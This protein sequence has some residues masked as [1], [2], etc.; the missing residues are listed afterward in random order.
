[1][2]P[3]KTG[4]PKLS[5]AAA[6]LAVIATAVVLVALMQAESGRYFSKVVSLERGLK[7]ADRAGE[8]GYRVTLPKGYRND[9]RVVEQAIVLEDGVPLPLRIAKIQ[10]VNEKGRGRYRLTQRVVYISTPDNSDPRSN[11]RKYE[12]S[13]PREVRPVALWLPL[14]LL[15][16]ALFYLQRFGTPRLPAWHLRPWVEPALVLAV[17]FSAM[18]W[19]LNHFSTYSDG[20][21]LNELDRR[22]K[23]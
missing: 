5:V 22:R 11:G 8:F 16:G 12:L 14:A 6:V 18:I 20:C 2:I 23:Y 1:M 10:H 7:T 19:A 17:S 4:N 3:S 15:T 21:G 9:Q 13:T